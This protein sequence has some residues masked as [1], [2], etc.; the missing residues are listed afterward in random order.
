[1]CSRTER[2]YVSVLPCSPALPNPEESPFPPHISA[3]GFPFLRAN[4]T[5][6]LFQPHFPLPL[7][8]KSELLRIFVFTFHTIRRENRNIRTFLTASQS[9]T[10]II[11]TYFM[12][13]RKWKGKKKKVG[14]VA[15]STRMLSILP[16]KKTVFLLPNID[17]G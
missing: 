16:N 10:N 9:A 5:A 14:E 3:L 13:Q 6:S 4:R 12:L 15:S 2:P 1:M 8:P 7:F 11:I 17:I